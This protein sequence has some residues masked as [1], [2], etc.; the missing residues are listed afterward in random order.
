MPQQV[1]W[2]QVMDSFQLPDPPLI[3]RQKEHTHSL[4]H[5]ETEI[6]TEK[7]KKKCQSA[8]VSVTKTRLLFSL[9]LVLLLRNMCNDKESVYTK[10]QPQRR[11]I[12]ARETQ[13]CSIKAVSFR[14]G[15]GIRISLFHVTVQCVL[16][17][18]ALF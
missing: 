12:K 3:T 2:L 9:Y 4:P 7:E 6:V 1:S 5:K 8:S 17:Q 18:S 10:D 11:R 13:M 15:C 14:S 16:S